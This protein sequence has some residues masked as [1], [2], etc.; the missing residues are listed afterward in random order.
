M[1]S[2]KRSVGEVGP[3]SRQFT[4]SL[5][6][7]D[8]A[9]EKLPRSLKRQ[10]SG[11]K[12]QNETVTNRTPEGHNWKKLRDNTEYQLKKLEKAGDERPLK[13]W[14]ATPSKEKKG[15]AAQFS[16]DPSC[17]WLTAEETH[18]AGHEE[19][20][21]SEE[22]WLTQEMLAG[23]AWLNS[24]EQAKLVCS[25]G[26]LETRKHSLLSLAAAGVLEYR[27]FKRWKVFENFVRDQ[28]AT[29]A[30]GQLDKSSYESLAG[31]MVPRQEDVK[32]PKK[33]L[34]K[35]LTG[36]AKAAKK[37]RDEMTTQL[38]S[39]SAMISKVTALE[40]TKKP[41]GGPLEAQAWLW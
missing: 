33:S 28:M 8:D 40:K 14:R 17:S 35:A 22:V 34:V 19:R 25:S 27:W 3:I 41:S 26:D 2:L 11:T 23:P 7:D 31:S 10:S 37:K 13:A 4:V 16:L 29:T 12:K 18:A 9:A 15:W 20:H 24:S 39:T 30:Q 32:V 36:E 6:P 21:S 38:R 5:D 1:S